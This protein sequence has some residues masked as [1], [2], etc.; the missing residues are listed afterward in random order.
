MGPER[1]SKLKRSLKT[2]ISSTAAAVVVGAL[3]TGCTVLPVALPLAFPLLVTGARGGINYTVTNTAY[4]TFSHPMVEVEES[5][6]SAI[7]RMQ[8]DELSTE[9][10]TDGVKITA[11][12]RK[13]NIHITLESITPATTKVKVNAK[14][15][16]VLKDKATAAEIIRQMEGVLEPMQMPAL[17]WPK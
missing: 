8:I 9:E 10:V 16:P 4:K 14:R 15:G 3:L 11:F 2:R 6:H 13:L 12:T 7:R 17:A 1:L 5:A